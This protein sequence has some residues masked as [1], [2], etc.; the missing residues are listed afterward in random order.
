MKR[1][2]LRLSI[3]CAHRITSRCDAVEMCGAKPEHYVAISAFRRGRSWVFE[4][5]DDLHGSIRNFV[6]GPMPEI[7]WCSSAL[8][9]VGCGSRLSRLRSETGQSPASAADATTT[10]SV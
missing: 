7:T 3:R 4:C 5:H 2:A 10:D 1:R 8:Q 6:G 9:P